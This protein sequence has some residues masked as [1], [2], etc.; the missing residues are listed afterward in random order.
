MALYARSPLSLYNVE[1]LRHERDIDV[2]HETVR[3]RWSR[4]GPD[5]TAEILWK[6]AERLRARPQRR[7]RLYEVF[8]KPDDQ[9]SISGAVDHE[10]GASIENRDD[11]RWSAG[12]KTEG[13]FDQAHLAEDAALRLPSS[14]LSLA[15]RAHGVAEDSLGRSDVPPGERQKSI[16]SPALTTA[17]WRYAQ[18]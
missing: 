8:V 12:A 14:R 4:F 6:G 1:D 2:T 9:N 3:F 13:S 15:D 10:S 7:R 16:V 17:G 18:Q 11:F 5:F